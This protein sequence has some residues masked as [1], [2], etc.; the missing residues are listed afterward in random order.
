MSK[1]ILVTGS[2]G[3][4]GSNIVKRLNELGEGRIFIV[5]N[6]GNTD[7]WRNLVGLDFEDYVQKD[8]FLE[9]VSKGA[10]GGK[11]SAI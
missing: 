9:K 3:F 8:V 2:A 10:F 1:A 11:I 4:I 5:D 6:L 7:K